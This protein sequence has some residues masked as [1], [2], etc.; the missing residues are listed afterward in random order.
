MKKFRKNNKKGFTL[1]E[2][3]VVVAILVALMLMLVPRLTGF[4]DDATKTANQA[5]ARAVYTAVKASE[6]ALSTGLY[7]TTSGAAN[8]NATTKVCGVDVFT[9]FWDSKETVST[10]CTVNYDASDTAKANAVSVT[11]GDTSK[12]KTV[13]TYPIPESTN[14]EE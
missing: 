8:Y 4:T 10:K 1:I 5:N 12:S 11:Y 2:L 13:G 3:I 14:E 6:T 9:A 7:S